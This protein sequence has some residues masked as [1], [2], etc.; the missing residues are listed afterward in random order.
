MSIT[1]NSQGLPGT[2][3]A[4]RPVEIKTEKPDHLFQIK[5][6]KIGNPF[7]DEDDIPRWAAFL[8]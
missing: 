6:D 8:Y 2:W 3:E 7:E 5:R 4:D 1:I